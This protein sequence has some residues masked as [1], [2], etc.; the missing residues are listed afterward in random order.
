M[1]AGLMLVSVCG[2]LAALLGPAGV[3]RPLPGWLVSTL[4]P[5]SPSSWLA[6]AH[7]CPRNGAPDEK[8]EEA[9]RVPGPR[10]RTSRTISIATF[11]CRPVRG[12]PKFKGFSCWELLWSPVAKGARRGGEENWGCPCTDEHWVLGAPWT[13]FQLVPKR[14]HNESLLPFPGGKRLFGPWSSSK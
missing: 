5:L 7:S 8:R 2:R 3:G 10:F 6:L 13:S 1:V 14:L 12:W 11:C 9:H 4:C